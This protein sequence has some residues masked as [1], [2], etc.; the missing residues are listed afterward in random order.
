MDG[1]I[2]LHRKLIDNPIICK[3]SDYFAVWCYL[4]LIATHKDVDILFAGERITL[5]AGQLITGRNSISNN[6]HINESKVKRILICF[7]NDQQIDRK[8]CNQ[9]SLIT[10]LNWEK[11][12]SGDQQSDQQVTNERP[13]SDQRVTTNK[14]IKNIKN[15]KNKRNIKTL[16]TADANALF[17]KLWELYPLKRGKGKVSEANKRRLLDIGEAAIVKAIDRYK[18][19]LANDTWRKPQNGST[20]FNSGYLDYL[21]DNYKKPPLQGQKKNKFTNFEQRDWNFEA[22]EEAQNKALEG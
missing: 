21:D 13:T 6:L 22:I 16:C 12:Q 3:D 20:F 18:A 15:I 4:L 2:K 7:E 11:Y 10:I 9:N 1:W 19:D 5:T 8:R 14:N 17:E